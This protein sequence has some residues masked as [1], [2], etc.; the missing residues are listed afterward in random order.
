MIYYDSVEFEELTEDIRNYAIQ[1]LYEIEIFDETEDLEEVINLI[2]QDFP[3]FCAII[4][5]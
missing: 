4:L 3:R 1:N 2:N 5:S